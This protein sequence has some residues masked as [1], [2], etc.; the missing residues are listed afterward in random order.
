M[1]FRFFQDAE[2][3]TGFVLLSESQSS[4]GFAARLTSAH[5]TE[6]DRAVV[7]QLL[8]GASRLSV[9]A[10]SGPDDGYADPALVAAQKPTA[11]TAAKTLE[12][13]RK[14]GMGTVPFVLF[15]DVPVKHGGAATLKGIVERV[16]IETLKE[17]NAIEYGY[18]QDLDRPHS[19]LLFEWWDSF[20]AM[21]AHLK[22]PHFTDLMR[23]F[24]RRR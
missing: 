5:S 11:P 6:F 15:V 21:N 13:L 10:E 19:F 18:F 16:R 8:T 22:L 14:V 2:R 3:S 4:G 9:A 7:A 23:A 12:R 24:A 20:A 17:P 1:F